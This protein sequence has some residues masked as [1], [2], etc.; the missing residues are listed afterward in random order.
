[1]RNLR[2]AA[3]RAALPVLVAAALLAAARPSGAQAPAAD[4]LQRELQFGSGLVRLGFP[5]FANRLLDRLELENPGAKAQ[6]ARVRVEAFTALGRADEA[7]A[8][9]K[10]FPPDSLDTQAMLLALGDA[11]YYRGKLAEARA[12]YERFFSQ[13]PNGPPAQLQGFYRESAYKYSQMMVLTGNDREALKAFKYVLLSKPEPD[14]ERRIQTETA[15]LCLKVGTASEGA[16]RE[17]FFKQAEQLASDVQWKG[18]DLWFGKTVVILAH[19]EMVRGRPKKAQEI[20]TTYLPMLKEIDAMLKDGG[21]PLKLSPM[22]ECRYLLGVLYEDEARA[23]VAEGKVD[24]SVDVFQKALQ[25]LYT[26]FLKYPASTWAPDAGARAERMVAQLR[27]MGRKVSVPEVDMA[28]VIEAQLSEARLLFQQQDYKAA[29]AKYLIVLNVFPEYPDSVQ[30]LGEL[31]QCYVNTQDGLYMNVVLRELTERYRVNPRFTEK[32]GGALLAMGRAADEI[33]DRNTADR[34]YA[35]FFDLFP[36]H[37][38]VP[39]VLYQLGE[40]RFQEEN[41]DFAL[42]YYEKIVRNHR[43]STAYLSALNKISFCYVK[44]GDYTNAVSTLTNYVAELQPGAALA[45]A[46]YRLADAWRQ[47]GEYAQA[48]NEYVRLIKALT[49]EAPRYANTAEEQGKN[50]DLLEQA[51]FWKAYCYSRLREPVDRVPAYLAKAVEDY[52]AFLKA[53]PKSEMAPAALSSMG[54]LLLM[55]EKSDAAAAVYER[56]TRDYPNSE[57]ARNAV[58]ARGQSLLEMGQKD[59]A[60]KVFEEMFAA[61][62]KYTPTQFLQAGMAMLDQGVHDMAARALRETL[63][64]AKERPVRDAALF[65]VAR[66]CIATGDFRGAADAVETLVKENPATGYMVEASFLQSRS[67]AEL[68][69]AES[70][71]S[72]RFGL[73]NEAVKAMNRGRKFMKTPEDRARS[74]VELAE[75]QLLM[76]NRNDAVASFQRIILL[77]D[78]DNPKVRP[79]VERAFETVAPLL[80]EQG[81]F[82]DVVDDVDIY[83]TKFPKGRLATQARQ[84]RDE[85]QRKMIGA[86]AAAPA[87]PATPAAPQTE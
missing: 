26:V 11:Q 35:M 14:I 9:I 5:D 34:I 12:I 40:R 55:Q 16:E 46:R 63:K 10:S 43:G 54:V 70:Q 25:H 15:E 27:E 44:G 86:A 57:Q 51:M 21:Y 65:G 62:G 75:I 74:D 13:Y 8:L 72:V 53:F 39:A 28:P 61:T 50:R 45:N 29:A 49:E 80:F 6:T 37:K 56:L 67:L 64:G 81:L 77:S 38:Q 33:Q 32:A 47:I 76:G 18:V 68:A 31:G 85:A 59:R 19:I 7:D 3:G 24:E 36:D 84:W 22:A 23:L 52:D 71:S 83:L 42:S 1:M 30:S 60:V 20:I 82:Q 78:S 58:F 79:F 66:A 87:A 4:P 69:K 17:S 41:Y 2:T 73:F 48:I